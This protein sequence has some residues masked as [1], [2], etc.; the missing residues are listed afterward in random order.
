[1]LLIE[2][3]FA[4]NMQNRTGFDLVVVAV[5]AELGPAHILALSEQLSIFGQN[6]EL[7]FPSYVAEVTIGSCLAITVLQYLI[8]HLVGKAK[9][10]QRVHRIN[11]V[12]CVSYLGNFNYYAKQLGMMSDERGRNLLDGGA[13]FYSIYPTREGMVAVGN[14]E[15]KFYTEMVTGMRLRANDLEFCL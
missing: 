1:V 6:G 8:A 5:G 2:E 7:F 13:P 10:E 4:K 11:C 12:E 9:G 3:K 14:L 15:P